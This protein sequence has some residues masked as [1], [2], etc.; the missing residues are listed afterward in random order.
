MNPQEFQLCWDKLLPQIKQK[1][2]KITDE[3]LNQINGKRDVLLSKIQ[4]KY[5]IKRQK[6]EKQL[7]HF[8][9]TFTKSASNQ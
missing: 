4:Q 1:F 6:A 7:K 9:S 3:D 8:E 2:D 5:G